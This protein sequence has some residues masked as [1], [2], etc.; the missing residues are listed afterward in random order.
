MIKYQNNNSIIIPALLHQ[1]RARCCWFSLSY[2]PWQTSCRLRASDAGW[3]ILGVKCPLVEP[4]KNVNF[5]G[6][7]EVV[8]LS[9]SVWNGCFYSKCPGK[10]RYHLC[11]LEHT[12]CSITHLL[13]C[14]CVFI[15]GKFF[16]LT[17]TAEHLTRRR[18]FHVRWALII[19]LS[20]HPLAGHMVSSNEVSGTKDKWNHQH[21]FLSQRAGMN[22]ME[23]R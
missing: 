6:S 18:P 15:S 9:T 21:F 3:R 1:Q 8:I 13:V 4:H 12:D 16:H 5:K 7:F 19:G 2:K 17:H 20:Q 22:R 11:H 10:V 23:K 14:V